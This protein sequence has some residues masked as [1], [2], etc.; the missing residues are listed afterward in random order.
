MVGGLGGGAHGTMVTTHLQFSRELNVSGPQTAAHGPH[1]GA[2]LPLPQAPFNSSLPMVVIL[3]PFH[4]AQ[5]LSGSSEALLRLCGE[6]LKT[7]TL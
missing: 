4:P 2:Y 1:L 3:W 6:Q 5:V 7:T